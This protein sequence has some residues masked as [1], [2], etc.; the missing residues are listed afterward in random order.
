MTLHNVADWFAAPVLA[1]AAY[2][3]KLTLDTDKR[4]AVL[5]SR[6]EHMD[7]KLDEIREDVH[8]IK[9]HIFGP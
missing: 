9:G 1:V 3:A 5:E 7:A 4:T 2:F 6:L 8:T